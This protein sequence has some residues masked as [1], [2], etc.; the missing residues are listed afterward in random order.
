M[1]YFIV[2]PASGSGRGRSVWN[3]ICAELDRNHISYKSFLLS[4]RGEARALAA[5]LAQSKQPFTLVVV[6][7]DGTINETVDGLFTGLAHAGLSDSQEEMRSDENAVI[8]HIT[9]GCIPTGSGNDFVRGLHLA[10]DPIEALHAILHPKELR[11]VNIGVTRSG[12]KTRF[13]AVS[14]GI[15]FDAAVC[16]CVLDSGLKNALNHFHSGKL[17]YLFTALW[18]L[19]TM[20]RQTLQITIDG[21]AAQTFPKAYFAAAMNLRY[22][23]GGFLFCPDAKPDDNCL[24]LIV[25]NNISRLR[26]LTVLPLALFGRHTN[27]RGITIR[28]CKTAAIQTTAP[29]T[30]HTDGE[31]PGSFDKVSFSLHEKKLAV[32]LR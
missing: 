25:A 8:P 31:I 18:L 30:V 7:G 20:E 29:L 23:G 10:K 3:T 4:R 24:D 11:P 5:S 14:S 13:F 15:G 9:F 16:S 6:G 19:L 1:Y 21:G 27:K 17:V 22:E 26:A 28:R 2:N 12:Q 32:I